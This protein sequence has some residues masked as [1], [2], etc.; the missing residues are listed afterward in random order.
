MNLVF[1]Y[2]LFVRW[3]VRRGGNGRDRHK[4]SVGDESATEGKSKPR[5]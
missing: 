1:R 4:G 5:A 3:R 2:G